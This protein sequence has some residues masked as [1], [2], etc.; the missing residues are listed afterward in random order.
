MDV[1]ALVL[2]TRSPL[3]KPLELEVARPCPWWLPTNCQAMPSCATE[4]H[5]SRTQLL[6]MAEAKPCSTEWKSPKSGHL[7]SSTPKKLYIKPASS[8]V[9]AASWWSS[10]IPTLQYFLSKSLVWG[11][12]FGVC[13]SLAPDFQG[14]F[15]FKAVTHPTAPFILILSHGNPFALAAFF[16]WLWL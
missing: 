10:G 1:N 12:L 8:L 3:F 7:E 15:L 11:L 4:N 9:L 16:W 13:Y 2:T 6:E 5:N 14:I